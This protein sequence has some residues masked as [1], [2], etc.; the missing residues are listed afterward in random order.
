MPADITKAKSFLYTTDFPIDKIIYKDEGSFTINALDFFDKVFAHNLPFA[1]LLLGTW[2]TTPDFS[3][4][5]DFG[6]GP[7][8]GNPFAINNSIS[9]N[10]SQVTISTTNNTNTSVTF[11]YKIYGF[12]PA[13]QNLDVPYT[14]SSADTYTFNTDFNY[15]K[16]YLNEIRSQPAGVNGIQN[17]VHN[18]GY[19][20]QILCW[21][22]ISGNISPTVVADLG[23]AFFTCAVT[24]TS[25]QLNFDSAPAMRIHV[26]VYL[27]D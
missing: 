11:Y 17:I 23:I 2:S 6:S 19:R 18:L 20:P 24:T 13:D 8:G 26:K 5:Y 1:P 7:L 3:I 27:D 22:E 15:S 21:Q 9:A 16:L 12:Q 25:V 4:S 14:S 10:S